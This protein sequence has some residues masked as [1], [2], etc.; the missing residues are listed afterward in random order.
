MAV[1]GILNTRY[2]QEWIG[3]L[4]PKITET[5][6]IINLPTCLQPSYRQL[7][8]SLNLPLAMC[9]PGEKYR[10]YK[11]CLENFDNSQMMAF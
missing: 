9:L 6:S 2:Y 8:S 4:E 10:Y 7:F 11:L 5:L 3:K 1:G